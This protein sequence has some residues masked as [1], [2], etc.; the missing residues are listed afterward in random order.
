MTKANSS[1]LCRQ[2]AGQKTAP[3]L[4][5]DELDV[6]GQEPLEQAVAV[7]AQPEQPVTFTHTG[8]GQGVGQ[9]VDPGVEGGKVEPVLPAH[10]GQ[11][12]GPVT[13][14]VTQNVGQGHLVHD[15]RTDQVRGRHSSTTRPA[16]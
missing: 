11:R 16:L 14:V 5:A 8:T 13:G 4:A 12:R 3:T 2:L 6:L 9:L 15:V 10:R 7:L 1:A